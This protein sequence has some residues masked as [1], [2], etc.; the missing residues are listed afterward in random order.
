MEYFHSPFIPSPARY[1]MTPSPGRLAVVRP[2]AVE[3]PLRGI[4]GQ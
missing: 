3:R 2:L 1:G 4:A